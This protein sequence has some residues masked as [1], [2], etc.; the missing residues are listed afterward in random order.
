[1]YRVRDLDSLHRLYPFP[2]VAAHVGA[3]IE[4]G[5]DGSAKVKLPEGK[6]LVMITA[7]GFELARVGDFSVKPAHPKP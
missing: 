5:M 4:T 6:Y 2:I 1:M 3:T 7:P